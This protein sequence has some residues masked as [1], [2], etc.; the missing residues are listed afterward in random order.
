[1][2]AQ[3]LTEKLTKALTRML[4]KALTRMLAKTLT[5][6]FAKALT[7]M[8]T[9]ALTRKLFKNPRDRNYC[10]PFEWRVLYSDCWC[11]TCCSNLDLDP[12]TLR[13]HAINAYPH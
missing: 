11:V 8:L 10:Y 9:K 1:M 5:G 6:K 4:T 12:N 2:F 7:R 13:N 3:T